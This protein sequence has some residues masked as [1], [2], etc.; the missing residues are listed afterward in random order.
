M[1]I[2]R[3]I[4][5]MD[6]ATGGPCQGIRYSIPYLQSE[7][8][9]NE[10]VCLDDPKAT[11]LDKDPFVI[12]ALG[13][14]M[15][16]LRYHPSLQSWLEAN[17]PS[18][19]AVIIHG[20]W[21]WPSI[22]T[23]IAIQMLRRKSRRLTVSANSSPTPS[24]RL[25]LTIP[26]VPPYFVM[27]HGMLDPWFQQEPGRRW[28]AFRNRIYWR[29]VEHRLIRDAAAVLFTCD[30]E[31]ELART[32][33]PL[34]APNR[35]INVGY[36]VSD[37][38]ANTKE[39]NCVFHNSCPGLLH[40]RPFLFFLGRIHP[41]KGV[42]LLIRA[43]AEVFGSQS[44]IKVKKSADSALQLPLPNSR[45]PALVIAGPIDSDY[46]REMVCLAESLLAGR[47]FT[48]H[49][50]SDLRSPIADAPFPMNYPS[51]H[52]TGMLQG[53]AKWGALHRCEA[54]VLP[55][56]QEN[57]GISVA[58]ALS[59][60]KPVLIADK[61]NIFREVEMARAGL[62]APDDLKGIT[63]LL[64]QW[65]NLEDDC[66]HRM[67]RN[68]MQLFQERFHNKTTALCLL[69]VLKKVEGVSHP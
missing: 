63:S 22:A 24:P 32:T 16:L 42:N 59:C 43:Y 21:L 46:A 18:Y 62:V 7:G 17:L 54:L 19:D 68:A 58:E 8:C 35:E 66:R 1:K 9:F 64:L 50:F 14:G 28:K 23:W 3:V 41:K 10:V 36:G 5:S 31:L 37:P 29:L 60:G 56:H 33:F 27:P 45:L 67:A 44:T 53:E 13:R 2:L 61:V 25:Q 12:Y 51:I 11:F 30:R 40:D 15:G 34:Y 69:E 65:S 6:P 48:P 39:M 49:S 38:P 57:F 55:S 20:L 52:F 26:K 4:A 47:I